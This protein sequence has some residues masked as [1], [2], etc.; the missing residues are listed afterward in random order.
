MSNQSKG[1]KISNFVEQSTIS[2]DD[3]LAIVTAATNR[4]IT[5][6]N[7]K[8]QLGAL[9]TLSQTGDPTAAPVLGGTGTNYKIRNIEPGSGIA[10]TISGTDGVEVKHS[11]LQDTVGAPIFLERTAAQPIFASIEAG[12]GIS[13]TRIDNHLEISAVATPVSTKTVVV[14][15][16][17]DLPTPAASV[18]TLAADTDYFFTNDINLGAN[19]L[20]MQNN[21]VIRGSDER[22]VKIT[23]TGSGDM[24]TAVAANV[25]VNQVR[26]N[27]A[28]G[29][30]YNFSGAGN[31]VV[32][33]TDVESCANVG[34][35]ASVGIFAIFR[36]NFE[37]ITASG[38]S[39]SGSNSVV[40]GGLNV[41]T[42]TAGTF[43]DLG[44]ATFFS[45]DWDNFFNTQS[46]GVT[47]LSGL[48]SSGNI[49]AGGLGRVTLGRLLGAGSALS[50]VSVD[51]ARWEFDGNNAIQDTRPDALISMQGN[52]TNTV[53]ASAGTPVLVA[54]TWVVEGDSQ[55]TSTTGGR[56]TYDGGKDS[57]L[58]L[59]FSCSVE[60]VSG[61]NISIS[62]LVAINGSV[63][64]NSERRGTASAGSPASITMPWQYTFQNGDYVEVFV[65]NDDN[66]TDILVSSAIG[67]I[68]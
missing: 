57:R 2:G 41:A 43:L 40:L 31:F 49:V 14:N 67:R 52:A 23:Y 46:A 42:Q 28:S 19:R 50:G 37:S 45:F 47:F 24:I 6:S 61:T 8:S 22:V 32:D 26:L 10:T 16:L 33:N 13:V 27:C 39:F 54:G 29:T 60:P 11:F 30:V 56:M 48:A 63:V 64:A 59:M 35:I 5:F 18:I 53:I 20:V 68:N 62:T 3:F 25:H 66:S 65:Q 4:K 51:D 38:F 17:S 15:E 7:F 58:P 9:G 55:F 12:D 1:R 36:C 34:T 44:T 21:T